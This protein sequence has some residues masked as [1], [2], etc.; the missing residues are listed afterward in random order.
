MAKGQRADVCTVGFG[1]RRRVRAADSPFH[2]IAKQLLSFFLLL[3]SALQQCLI[4]S[5]GVLKAV[6][7]GA[8][9]E[10]RGRGRAPFGGR[11][12]RR[13]ATAGAWRGLRGGARCRRLQHV[14]VGRMGKPGL[15]VRP[16]VLVLLRRV[17]GR[18]M[19]SE[20]RRNSNKSHQRRE[21]VVPWNATRGTLTMTMCLRGQTRTGGGILQHQSSQVLLAQQRAAR[22][23]S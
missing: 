3:H 5:Y 13:R 6:R 22:F 12:G 7:P 19:V 2:S 4:A 16:G 17:I 23:G 20:E 1:G 9:A 8:A 15:S 21:A 18:G 11:R 14:Q 10:R